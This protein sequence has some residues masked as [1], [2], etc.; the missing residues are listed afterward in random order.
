MTGTGVV[1]DS[2][3][4]D[5]AAVF[6]INNG[7]TD[8]FAGSLT[9]N[10]DLTKSNSGTL[11]LSS[12][13]SFGGTT[14]ISAGIL[15][16]G[17]VNALP[18]GT[19]LIVSG[20]LDLAGFAQQVASVTGS[21]TV[22]NSGSAATFTVSNSAAD[23]F[24]GKL[25]G[26][27]ALAKSGGG[28]LVLP[29]TNTYSGS[30]VVTAGTLE[31]DGSISSNVTISGTGTL[32]GVGTTGSVTASAGTLAP[33]KGAPGILTT[34]T[35]NLKAGSAFT[36][37]L[38][39]NT[40]G[41][42]SEDQLSSGTVT[43]STTAAGV[44]LNLADF[45]YTLQ[46][47]DEYIILAN[48]GSSPISGRFVAGTGIDFVAPGT[49][50]PEGTVL[51]TNFLASGLSASITYK[52]GPNNNSVGIKIG[53]TLRVDISDPSAFYAAGGPVTYTVT[54]SDQ[55]S[56]SS[57]LT[58]SNITL[59]KTG[60]ANGSVSLSGSGTVYT[61]TIGS[62]T[63]DGTLS[64]SLAANTASDLANNEAPAAGPSNTIIVDNTPP[65][66]TIG[67]PSA[68]ITASNSITYTI[69]YADANFGS[70]SLT[71]GNITLN[72]T[73]TAN[74]TVSVSGSGT[75]YTVT[76]SSITGDGS[77]GI[78]LASNTAVDLA[79]NE[80]PAS[81]PSTTF[82][83]DNTPP[84][85]TIGNPSASITASNSITYS[86]SYADINFASSSLTAGNITLNKTGSANGFVSVTGSGT[87]YTATI[88]GITGDGTLGITIAGGTAVDLAGNSA[89][90]DVGSTFI[91]DN[92]RP[93][94]T[95][96][97]PSSSITASNSITY[98]ISYADANFG[99]SGLTT[100]NITLNKTGSANGT[101][102]L[103][104]AGTS[105]TVTISGITGDGSLGISLAANT[106]ID[107]AGNQA[108]G[109]GPSTTFI[110]DNTPPAVTVHNPSAPITASG[111]ITYAVSYADV[112]FATSSLTASGIT[113]NKTGT[114]NG[115]V[116][117]SGSGTSYTVTIGN[118]MGDGTLGLSISAGSASDLAGNRALSAS[119]TTFIVDNTPPSVTI[120]NPSASITGSGSI[121]YTI[122]YAD[123]NFGSSSLT[124]SNLILNETG[125]ANGTLSLIGSGTSYTATI[126]G[127]T[128]DGTLGISVGANTAADQVGNEAAA[129]GPSNTF[130]VD[131]TPPSVTISSPS[132]VYTAGGPI[133]YTVTYADAN[134]ASSGLTAGNLT[135]NRTGTANGIINV[136]GSGLA[137]TVTISSITGDGTLGL[138][139]P[140]NTAVDLAGNKAGP[141]G[142][143]NTL[144]VDNTA[145]TVTLGLPSGSITAGGPITYSINY[146]DAN[147]NTSNLRASNITLNKTGTANG[148]LSLSGSGT[149]YTAKIT[150]IT[151]DGTLSISLAANTA[152]DLAGNQAPAA[153]SS[154]FLVDN[155][156]PSV[157]ISNPSASITANGTISYNVTYADAN[158]GSSSLTS[159]NI[160]LNRTG[161]AN[162]SVSV[163]GFGT[164]YTVTV[165]GI[166]GDGT[167]GISLAG[168][169]AVDRAG[170]EAPAASSSTFLVDNT[171]PAL[172]VS[173]PS[174]SIIAGGSITYTLA[175][176]DTNF[177]SS[178]LTTGNITLNKTGTANGSLTLTGSGTS[179][180]VTIDGITGD[181][182][183]GIS[184]APG[185][186]ADLA[187]NLAAAT[188]GSTVIVDNTPPAL[189]LSSPSKSITAGGSITY[190]INYADANFA[191]SSLTAGNI[192]LNKTGTANG[193]LS[194]SGSGT[195]YTATIIGITGDGTLGISIAA[196]T[197]VDLAGN[198]AP[199]TS[200]STF[201]VDNT[202]PTLTIGTPSSTITANGV[203]TYS[204]TYADANFASSSLVSGNITLNKTGTASGILSLIGSGTTYTA[205]ISNLSGDGTLGLSIAGNTAIDLAGNK[206]AA[207]GPSTTFLVDNTAPSITVSSPSSSITAGGSITYT[208]SYADT[209]FA[210]SNL[211]TGSII[212][213]STGT[214]NGIVSVSGTGTSYTVTISS[215][216][217]DGSLG[218][219]VAGETAVDLAG[220]QAPGASGTTFLV[221]NTPPSMTI[222]APSASVITHGL[223]SYTVSY[224]DFNFASSIL[225]PSD[226]TL[227]KTGTAT[228][229]LSLSGSG[230][231]Y[232]VLI[233]GI[234]GDGTLGF[235]VAAGSAVDL[236]GNQAPAGSSTTFIV[237]NTPP[238][239]IISQPS[240]SI[241]AGSAI[242]YTVS[243]VDANFAASSLTNSNVSLNI[244]GT[245]NGVVSVSGSGTS[246]TVTI[247]SITGDGALGISV[248]ANT[249][250]DL[251]SH[252]A[253][254]SGPSSTFIVDNTP[255]SIAVSDPSDFL[256][257]HGPITYSVTYSDTNFGSSSL[258]ASDIT[259][260]SQGT[261]NG[262]VSVSGSGTSYT[263]TI[264]N[265]TGDG[266]LG[267]SVAG[268]SAVDLAGNQAPAADSSTFD[269]DNS[270]PVVILSD[271]AP[272][273]STHQSIV[274]ALNFED[275]N[276]ASSS[277]TLSNITLNKTGTANGVVSLAGTGGSYIVTI[278]SITGDGTVGISV[279]ANTAVDLL[280]NK[281]LAATSPTVIVDNT[282]PT[283]ALGTPSASVT[284]HGPVTYI[285]TY[286][287]TNFQASTLSTSDVHLITTGTAN[288]TLSFDNST[289]TTRTITIGNITGDGTLGIKIDAGSGVDQAGNKAPA[290]G[291][292]K[293]FL[294]DNTQPVILISAPTV[295]TTAA[296]AVKYTVTYRDTNLVA[297]SISLTTA[298]ITLNTTNPHQTATVVVTGTG[299]TRTVTLSGITGGKGPMGISIASGTAFD[300][301]GNPAIASIPSITFNVTGSEKLVLTSTAATSVV[302][303]NNLVYTF[304]VA[305]NGTQQ[306][307]GDMLVLTPPTGVT[308]NAASIPGWTLQSDGTYL[309]N[310]GNMKA[311]AS[312]KVTFTV[313]VPATAT[314]NSTL[315]ESISLVDSFGLEATGKA[316]T[317][318]KKS[319]GRRD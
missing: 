243:Y 214:A 135:L 299:T 101:V 290:I 96:G 153:G 250:V 15:T 196:N 166:N 179:Y 59:N 108:L 314:V 123:P 55:I 184:V 53:P 51:S 193:L 266:P 309:Y 33:G 169:T 168:N 107:L 109:T 268:A 100:G 313:S 18:A 263:V 244:T 203:I 50:L 248:A 85:L 23:N 34:G 143:S 310:I 221:D 225:S 124:T 256:T 138:S 13:N 257:T 139:I 209:N 68:S 252:Q 158:F 111:S 185:T 223:I 219:S 229:T 66:V 84:S 30:T 291:P 75:S 159:N 215:I 98:S 306:T 7:A 212:L 94:V 296:G 71:A 88:S 281:S 78:S 317:L 227:N 254:A 67:K 318:V 200:S 162:G 315:V 58:T 110:V 201:I 74:G 86:I 293:T 304:T 206:A 120:S 60:T 220:N 44:A 311:G 197:A 270:P 31:V 99:S 105:Y 3:A 175:Y 11:T 73:G 81:G 155:T 181:G 32:D 237:D 283:I 29:N 38:G 156:P 277:L 242:T 190:S 280:G 126:S 46:L 148:I 140:G 303:G 207:S 163:F 112:N 176:A 41:T 80:A 154:T 240:A 316:N 131:N 142:P 57:H 276:F 292:S 297:S 42:Y 275:D 115:T 273:I 21:G 213:K 114:A 117:V 127:I 6:T 165:S 301:A 129:A 302:Q 295:K 145:P 287:D 64:I 54:Y 251:A 77:L 167:L 36:A 264:S 272:S 230:T 172:T 216:T 282:P 262:T 261:A 104:G 174:Q 136:V 210:S 93:S 305:N 133:T 202:A 267:I 161:T 192:T 236:A 255:P 249:A 289:G 1:T 183:L 26:S 294:V 298:D 17:I 63:G 235:S 82:I 69:S 76:I 274:Y 226:V 234:T 90:A 89:A 43:L 52:A 37:L 151:G 103:S 79:G 260:D 239:V 189:T 45:S 10:L 121:S 247:S 253:P 72:T 259:L 91:V 233:S 16:D 118:I 92:T 24:A 288:G 271:P 116:S 160:T 286:A 157:T 62:I 187:G 246:Y 47:N 97:N 65:S 48:V 285:V 228:G 204:I 8:T 217:G 87:S 231:S 35:L 12:A 319:V 106:A 147:F 195:S 25:T 141:A 125:T 152:V 149:T 178:S 27:L 113:L 9:G 70:G 164:S 20:T 312:K 265:I 205:I 150:G 279:P 238:S 5:A 2:D 146:A 40:T 224:A 119:G 222:S 308:I 122:T 300:I 284:G 171:P 191:S 173:N 186:A 4:A 194:L 61:V 137:Y 83:V 39:G 182:T 269:V 307:F 218:I 232:T 208:I 245:A 211:T 144:I 188:S 130:I 22:T 132:S 56:V 258:T 49:A 199:A 278:S 28:T 95:I 134:F 180:T 128:G 177:A 241:T 170:N 19:G 198:E 102:S 14:T